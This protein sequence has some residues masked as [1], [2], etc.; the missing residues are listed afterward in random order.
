MLA[1][2]PGR[3]CGPSV[4]LPLV[5]AAALL[6]VPVLPLTVGA[7]GAAGPSPRTRTVAV[8]AVALGVG[9]AHLTMSPGRRCRGQAR[10]AGALAPVAPVLR[11]VGPAPAGARPVARS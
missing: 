7:A 4:Q 8:P 2:A 1:L 11:A 6:E 9:G 5:S 10:D 3:F